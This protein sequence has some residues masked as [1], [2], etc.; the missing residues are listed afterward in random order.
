M[1]LLDPPTRRLFERAS[2]AARRRY[3]F[4]VIG[5]VVIPEHVHLLVT[6]PE[7]ETLAVAVRPSKPKAGLLG[8]PQAMKQSV[9]RQ[10]VKV[11][12]HFW[13]PQ[14][15]DFNVWSEKKRIEKLRYIHRNPGSPARRVLACWGES[16][17]GGGL[18]S[19]RRIGSLPHDAQERRVV[20]TPLGAVT[21]TTRRGGRAW[22]R[23]NRSGRHGPESVWA[24]DR[25]WGSRKLPHPS[26][27]PG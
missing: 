13:Q 2:E 25:K 6:E 18:S 26:Q 20:G 10:R 27:K 3:G 16:R 1:Q 22:S 5:Y 4:R 7:R 21:D 14:Y 19:G 8:T 17:C 11:G 15:Y 24:G 9:L 12:E 23:S